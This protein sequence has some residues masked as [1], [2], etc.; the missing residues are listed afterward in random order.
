[1]FI[2]ALVTIFSKKSIF[3][4]SSSVFT[5]TVIKIVCST[6][7]LCSLPSSKIDRREVSCKKVTG[8]CTARAVQAWQN[9]NGEA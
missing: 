5:S 1:M 2:Y 8:T 6:D 7:P 4:L 9:N 3:H